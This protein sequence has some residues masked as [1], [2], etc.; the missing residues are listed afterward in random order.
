M[1]AGLRTSSE[2]MSSRGF[3]GALQADEHDGHG[4]G[5]I[6]VNRIALLA[7]RI[8][9]LIVHD[10]HDHLTGCDRPDHRNTHRRALH[11]LGE[12]A[13]HIEGHVG[14]EKRAAYLAQCRIDIRLGQRATPREAIKDAAEPFGQ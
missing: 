11:L 1:A 6:E 7:K 3:A 2:A 5:R 13:H 14:L 9:E 8:D 10:L 4:R 12:R